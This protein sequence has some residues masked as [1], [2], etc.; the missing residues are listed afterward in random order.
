MNWLQE[1]KPVAAILGLMIAGAAGLGAWLYLSWSAYSESMD[2]WSASDSQLATLRSKAI[3][4]TEQNVG[5]MDKLVTEYADKVN[6]LRTALLSPKVQQPIKAMSETEFQTK[7]KERATNMKKLA[8]SAGM[9]ELPEDFA[10]GFDEYAAKIPRSADVAAELNVQLDVMDK[11]LTT[12]VESGITSLDSLERTKLAN[13]TAP[14][15]PKPAPVVTKKTSTKGGKAKKPVIT[16]QAAAEPVLD[17]YPVKIQFTCDQGPFQNVINTLGNP[18]KMPHFLV[19]RLLRV[20]NERLDGPRRDE[21]NRP[22]TPA[23]PEAAPAPVDAAATEPGNAPVVQSLAP[24][25]PAP[26]DA[27][28]IMGNELLKVQLEVDYIR[29]RPAAEVEDQEAEPAKP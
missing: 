24:P 28:A 20:D 10:L 11:L 13:E 27:F 3:E 23:T 2:Q 15:P 12:L 16:E 21:V 25:P 22:R 26:A 5:T 14:L 29:F 6:L 19:V 1:N 17:R 7:L 8:R 4:P 18:T 9:K